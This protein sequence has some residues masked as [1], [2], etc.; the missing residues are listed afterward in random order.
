MS[1]QP[2]YVVPPASTRPGDRHAYLP[3]L[4]AQ[5]SAAFRSFEAPTNA[6]GLETWR[7]A[8]DGF[9]ED[10]VF[11]AAAACVATMR[12][13]PAIADLRDELF[14]QRAE[15]ASQVR[16]VD[17]LVGRQSSLQAGRPCP[18][19]HAVV[20]VVLFTRRA[21]NSVAARF[22]PCHC[23]PAY[24]QKYS[25]RVPFA[26]VQRAGIT[27]ASIGHAAPDAVDA[28]LPEAY[29]PPLRPVVPEPSSPTEV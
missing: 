1:D 28:L 29:R 23:A 25:V 9:T 16:S 26:A 12:R 8:L 14:R 27:L 17:E 11:S 6:V 5:L 22:H 10:E 19:C 15:R 2:P 24:D 20:P 13:T 3:T 21:D 4:F 7:R 18:V